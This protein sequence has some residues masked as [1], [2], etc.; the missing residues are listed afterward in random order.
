M[1]S[2]RRRAVSTR[3]SAPSSHVPV[4]PGSRPQPA[5]TGLDR[6]E[7]AQ[8]VEDHTAGRQLGLLGEPRV[9]VLELHLAPHDLE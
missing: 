3:T 1:G 8:L 9:N 2:P 5:S 7:V 4:W 6:A